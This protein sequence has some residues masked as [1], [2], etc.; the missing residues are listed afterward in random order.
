TADETARSSLP[1]SARARRAG[2]LRSARSS[3]PQI[4]DPD[5]D[6]SEQPAQQRQRK[7]DHIAVVALDPFDEWSGEAVESERTGHLH[8]FA[9]FDVRIEFVVCRRP[10]MHGRTC[11][12]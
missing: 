3:A 4:H 9:G 12:P 5:I 6:V 7:A 2:R 10:E 1:P 8:R 11:Y